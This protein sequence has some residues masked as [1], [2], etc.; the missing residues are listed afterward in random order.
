MRK[1]RVWLYG[2]VLCLILGIVLWSALALAAPS[3]Q[4]HSEPLGLDVD[5]PVPTSFPVNPDTTIATDADGNTLVLVEG[6]EVV[7]GEG[8]ITLNVPVRALK[9]VRVASFVDTSTG[10][11]ILDRK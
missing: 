1:V 10:V 11:N 8:S 6:G 7:I 2:L 9:G 3:Q 5:A 4:D